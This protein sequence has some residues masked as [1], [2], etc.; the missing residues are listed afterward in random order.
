MQRLVS[1]ENIQRANRPFAHEHP[2]NKFPEIHPQHPAHVANEV[3]RRQREETP[4]DDDWQ[5]VPLQHPRHP[6]HPRRVLAPKI[7]VQLQPLRKIINARG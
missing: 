1:Q 3:R 7:R 6:R 5:L 4:G 2:E